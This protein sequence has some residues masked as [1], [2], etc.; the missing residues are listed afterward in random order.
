MDRN[1]ERSAAMYQQHLNEA[2]AAQIQQDRRQEAA[3][4]RSLRAAADTDPADEISAL[5]EQLP[6]PQPATL[7]RLLRALPVIG[8]RRASRTATD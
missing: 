1:S 4:E 2:R 5:K 3:I 7:R 6:D 8:R